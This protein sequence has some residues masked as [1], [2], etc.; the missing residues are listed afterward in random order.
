[1]MTMDGDETFG[2]TMTMDGD[3]SFGPMDDNGW[4]K[5]LVQL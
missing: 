5:P 4:W 3:E 1:M 2:P